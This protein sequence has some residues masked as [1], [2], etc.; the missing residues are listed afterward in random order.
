VIHF[1]C[2]CNNNESNTT[3]TKV[4][5]LTATTL[6]DLEHRCRTQLLPTA[7][8]SREA[9]SEDSDEQPLVQ[10]SLLS[11][12]KTIESKQPSSQ[13]GK[14][15]MSTQ[16]KLA[17][18]MKAWGNKAKLNVQNRP[19]TL[20]EKDTKKT[21]RVYTRLIIRQFIQQDGG[22]M[23]TKEHI[24]SARTIFGK[25]R[26][27][28]SFTSRDVTLQQAFDELGVNYQNTSKGNPLLLRLEV[29][30][31]G[32]LARLGRSGSITDGK[33]CTESYLNTK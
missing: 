25:Q 16:V 21:P 7:S 6:H 8:F 14:N 15:G 11:V 31:K 20:A 4:V 2:H 26:S 27:S 23:C 5:G 33:M 24:L 22:S 10:Q 3:S 19:D 29:V 9:E 13:S 12:F 28:D 1:S 32:T 17:M 30:K 18:K